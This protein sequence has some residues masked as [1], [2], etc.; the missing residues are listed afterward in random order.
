[1]CNK[2]INIDVNESLS[3]CLDKFTGGA[4]EEDREKFLF[5]QFELLAKKMIFGGFFKVR[6][7]YAIFIDTV[8]FYFHDERNDGEVSIKDKIVYHRNGRFDFRNEKNESMSAELP[9]FPKMTLH[10]HWSGI[11]IT[12]E[13]PDEQYR[14][15]A[16]IRRYVV[17]DIKKEKYIKLD[18]KNKRDKWDVGRMVFQDELHIDNRSTYLQYF[19]NGFS[20]KAGESTVFWQDIAIVGDPKIKDN[21]HARQHAEDHDW[22]F[23]GEST[24]AY[25]KDC[26]KTNRIEIFY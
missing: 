24:E 21:N 11:D 4:G 12:F 2:Q 13:N 19:L 20:A 1:M 5:E 14:A 8:E 15:S 26:I 10:V 6:E 3:T 18:T 16:L 7:D 25:I 17:Y 9:Y 23:S 22:A